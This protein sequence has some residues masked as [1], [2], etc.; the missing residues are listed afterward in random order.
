MQRK[1]DGSTRRVQAHLLFRQPD[2]HAVVVLERVAERP[3]F[4]PPLLADLQVPKQHLHLEQ[5]AVGKVFGPVFGGQHAR[6][7]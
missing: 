3:G 4:V 7:E 5:Y 1:G 6:S 2:R